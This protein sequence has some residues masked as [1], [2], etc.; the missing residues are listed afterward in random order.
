MRLTPHL[1]APA[2]G[3]LGQRRGPFSVQFVVARCSNTRVWSRTAVIELL[4]LW[5]MYEKRTPW[6]S[7]DLLDVDSFCY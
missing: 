3:A 5:N 4:S 2:Q 6:E 1:A 7:F